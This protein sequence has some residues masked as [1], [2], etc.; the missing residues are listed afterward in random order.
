[1]YL[2]MCALLYYLCL[3]YSLFHF[4]L[5][6][7]TTPTH[8]FYVVSN[9]ESRGNMLCFPEPSMAVGTCVGSHLAYSVVGR[10]IAQAI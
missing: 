7:D 8:P 4:F 6:L 5:P 3:K 10:K 2:K 9:L 1:M